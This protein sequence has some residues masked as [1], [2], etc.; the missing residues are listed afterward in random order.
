VRLGGSGC[1]RG[2]PATGARNRLYA[3]A[4]VIRCA[5]GDRHRAVAFVA[6]DN[7]G[8]EVAYRTG[9]YGLLDIRRRAARATGIPSGA[10]VPA[11]IHSHA[12]PDLIGAWGF[13]ARWYLAQ[14]CDGA[15]A[16]LRR[17]ARAARPLRLRVGSGNGRAL[18]H[19]QF[20]DPAIGSLDDPDAGVRVLR[21]TDGRGRGVATLVAFAAHA[22]VMGSRNT[23]ASPDWPGALA[24]Q[25]ERDRSRY[26]TLAV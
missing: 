22:T 20:D 19:T 25:L 4:V 14:V 7:Q 10:I 16:A 17:A 3:R 11:T 12:G 24:V 9:P 8:M 15:V 1:G 5:R 2:R 23:G 18:L 26:S 21:A 6:I 13:V